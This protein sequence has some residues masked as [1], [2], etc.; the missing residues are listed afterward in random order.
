EY[1]PSHQTKCQ[2]A[3]SHKRPLIVEWPAPDRA[4]L[5]ASTR[6]GIVVVRYV[7][8]EMEVLP[9]CNVKEG[10]YT[11]VPTST[12]RDEVR[13]RDTD[14]LYGNLP[15]GATKLE[16]RLE[17][18]GEL[19]VTM[20][21]VGA[22]TAQAPHVTYDDLDG[23]CAQATHVIRTISVG[24]FDFYQEGDARVAGGVGLAG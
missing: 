5:E 10:K 4:S 8:C 6:A 12:Y 2:V 15:L 20:S 18:G 22:Y 3:A 13:I 17:R 7:G 11:F 9:A 23:R 19:H 16:G 1:N 24:A 14:E 21:V